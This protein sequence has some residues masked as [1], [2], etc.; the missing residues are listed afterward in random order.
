MKK[1]LVTIF[2]LLF[3]T[4]G[5]FAQVAVIAHKF[6]PEDTL[7]KSELLDFYTCDI[8]K[9][10]NDLPVIV[11]DLKPKGEVKEIFYKFLGKSSSRMKSIWLKKMLSGEGDPPET[12]KSE[13]EML[14]KIT[15]T[16]G[17]IG[18]VSQSIV[19]GEVKTLLVINKAKK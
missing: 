2:C 17:A 13:E 5:L 9:W 6:V 14:N 1:V 11:L 4:T 8:K 7:K 10:S 19:S 18:F 12:L 3:C 16:P 15:S